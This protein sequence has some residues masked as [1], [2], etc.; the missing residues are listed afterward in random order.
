MSV[1][2]QTL[3]F[4]KFRILS[5]FPSLQIGICQIRHDKNCLANGYPANESSFNPAIVTGTGDF[6]MKGVFELKITIDDEGSTLYSTLSGIIR[7]S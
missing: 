6:G 3:R 1:I 5:N 2:R 7:S 4:F